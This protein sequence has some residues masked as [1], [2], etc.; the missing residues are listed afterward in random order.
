MENTKQ[1]ILQDKLDK[2]AFERPGYGS[3]INIDTYIKH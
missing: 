2:R 1:R 3:E